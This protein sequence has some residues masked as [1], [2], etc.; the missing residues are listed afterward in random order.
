[1]AKTQ[2]F[3]LRMEPAQRKQ[4]DAMAARLGV[5]S[6]EAA[7]IALTVGLTA[8]QGEYT[9]TGPEWLQTLMKL[10]GTTL[11]NPDQQPLF[12]E[13]SEQMDL[14]HLKGDPGEA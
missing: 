13:L 1:M 2:R 11:A 8:I 7:R 10:V 5:S 9:P 12:V 3:E 14:T 4:L 6:S